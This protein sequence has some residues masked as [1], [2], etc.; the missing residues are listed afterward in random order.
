[1]CDVD[2]CFWMDKTNERRYEYHKCNRNLS[3]IRPEP[4]HAMRQGSIQI[5]TERTPNSVPRASWRTDRENRASAGHAQPPDPLV[6]I[7][8][9]SLSELPLLEENPQR[10]T[11]Y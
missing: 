6:D 11:I 10:N 2:L 5:T 7:V 8:C 3:Q 9:D 1:M 4:S